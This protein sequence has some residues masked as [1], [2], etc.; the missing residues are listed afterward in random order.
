MG[1][2]HRQRGVVVG[3]KQDGGNVLRSLLGN[4]LDNAHGAAIASAMAV[5]A[6]GPYDVARR[7]T[8]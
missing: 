8:R 5:A 7:L 2:V 3:P 6:T 4:F 1:E